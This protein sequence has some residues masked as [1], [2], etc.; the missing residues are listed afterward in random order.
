MFSSLCVMFYLRCGKDIELLCLGLFLLHEVG[1]A[2][3]LPRFVLHLFL[4]LSFSILFRVS[5]G[6][7]SSTCSST[8]LSHIRWSGFP[9]LKGQTTP[10]TLLAIGPE[11]RM[12]L[13][14]I[15]PMFVQMI[16]LFGIACLLF[17]AVIKSYDDDE[18]Q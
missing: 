18:E 14:W 5:M 9:L 2:G 13:G 4:C 10:G 8:W 16:T 6:V 7:P 12:S 1:D 17:K 15:L 11:R 3:Q